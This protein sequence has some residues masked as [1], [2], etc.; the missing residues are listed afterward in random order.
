MLAGWV[1]KVMSHLY[2][3]SFMTLLWWGT[4]PMRSLAGAVWAVLEYQIFFNVSFEGF[5]FGRQ[6]EELVHQLFKRFMC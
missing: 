4:L 1:T 6:A 3:A 5:S 2:S